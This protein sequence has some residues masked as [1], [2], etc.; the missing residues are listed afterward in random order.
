MNSN[1]SL[2]GNRLSNIKNNNSNVKTINQLDQKSSLFNFKNNKDLISIFNSVE[3]S[4]N[5]DNNNI[6]NNYRNSISGLNN[7]SEV[8][9]LNKQFSSIRKNSISNSN[10]NVELKLK[11][12]N[13]DN[14][15]NCRNEVNEDLK[16]NE[17]E[18][19]K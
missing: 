10:S 19:K 8:K 6:I 14:D 9:N 2:L 16:G 12:E 17:N 7:N 1:S 5:R 13:E 11:E 18:N 3:K 15:K 4:Q